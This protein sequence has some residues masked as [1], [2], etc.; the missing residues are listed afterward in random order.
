MHGERRRRGSAGEP[1]LNL[2]PPHHRGA[3][4]TWACAIDPETPDA[5]ERRWLGQSFGGDYVAF[6]IRDDGTLTDRRRWAEIPGTAPDGCTLD[7]AGGIW[8]SD[9]LGSQVVRVEAGGTVTDRLATP[10]PTFACMLGG[11]DGR[12]LF[13]LCS[14]GSHPDESAG[15]G[16]GAIH[17]VR[18]EHPRAGRP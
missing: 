4:D 16:A 17:S 1:A 7:G 6:T 5:V 8:F 3:V 14:P 2:D 10:M 13:A 15:L 9:A 11:H 18:V 12:T